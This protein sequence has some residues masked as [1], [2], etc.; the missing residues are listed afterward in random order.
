VRSPHDHRT[1]S[2]T[3]S[4][5]NLNEIR[6]RIDEVKDEVCRDDHDS[7]WMWPL[8]CPAK[9]LGRGIMR[10]ASPSTSKNVHEHSHTG[11]VPSVQTNKALQPWLRE[12]E[13]SDFLDVEMIGV[14]SSVLIKRL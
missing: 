14:V 2:D 12:P 7:G 6:P 10:A 13:I 11:M 3:R 8:T 4:Q 5:S 1:K 9:L